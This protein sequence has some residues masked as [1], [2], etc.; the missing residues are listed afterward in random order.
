MTPIV[1]LITGDTA[2]A[3]ALADYLQSRGFFAPAIRPPTVAP[4]SARV[5]VTL[6]ADFDDTDIDALLTALQ[7]F[8]LPA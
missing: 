8:G 3:L 4:G 6:R 5:R 1:P 2:R 7:E